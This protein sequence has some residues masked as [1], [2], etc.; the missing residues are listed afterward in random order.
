MPVWRI[1]TREVGK[2]C[3][4]QVGDVILSNNLENKY[5]LNSGIGQLS[6]ADVKSAIVYG[7]L[8][9]LLSMLLYAISIGDVFAVNSHA[10]VNAGFFG[11]AAVIV[12]F[13]KNLLT[14]SSGNFAGI[15]G[16]K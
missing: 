4:S 10:L 14:T 13:I 15:V 6:Y 12:S 11:G 16:I 7:I 3:T 5:M 9:A 2:D 1:T 8:A